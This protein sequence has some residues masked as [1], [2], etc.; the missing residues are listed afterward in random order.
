MLAH[1]GPLP[2]YAEHAAVMGDLVFRSQETSRGCRRVSPPD[3]PRPRSPCRRGKAARDPRPAPCG[4]QSEKSLV[5]FVPQPIETSARPRRCRRLASIESIV[6]PSDST[7]SFARGSRP[8]ARHHAI[9][10]SAAS[11]GGFEFRP[12]AGPVGRPIRRGFRGNASSRRYPAAARANCRRKA[13]PNLPA[14]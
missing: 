4:A 14:P 11:I 3:G 12:R 6:M 7:I 13:A 1:A 5:R 8:R 9:N 10:S 2:R